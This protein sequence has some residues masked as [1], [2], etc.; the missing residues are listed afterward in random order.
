MT[1]QAYQLYELIKKFIINTICREESDFFEIQNEHNLQL[2]SNIKTDP[3]VQ[4]ISVNYFNKLYKSLILKDDDYIISVFNDM[5]KIMPHSII[6]LLN[7]LCRLKINT[8]IA[9]KRQLLN[10]NNYG[11]YSASVKVQSEMILDKK[12]YEIMENLSHQCNIKDIKDYDPLKPMF[13]LK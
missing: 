8:H 4:H 1:T 10:I 6:C 5:I 13:E 9:L 2:D 7:I 3:V 11:N 12:K